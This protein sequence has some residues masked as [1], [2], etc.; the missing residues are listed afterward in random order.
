MTTEPKKLRTFNP[1]LAIERFDDERELFI[2]TRLDT[3]AR[4]ALR[5]SANSASA[6]RPGYCLFR[7]GRDGS[8]RDPKMV[9]P[10]GGVLQFDSAKPSATAGET[11]PGAD[12]SDVPVFEAAW[13]WLLAKN[14]ADTP[15]LAAKPTRLVRLAKSGADGEALLRAD[16]V[17]ADYAIRTSVSQLS[18]DADGATAIIGR[19]E[20]GFAAAGVSWIF[21]GTV[22]NR[23]RLLLVQTADQKSDGFEGQIRPIDE[24]DEVLASLRQMDPQTPVRI[25]PVAQIF[26]GAVAKD[27]ARRIADPV[28]FLTGVNVPGTQYAESGFVRCNLVVGRHKFDSKGDDIPD[29]TAQR[30]LTVCG[31]AEFPEP[32]R[33]GTV[34]LAAP[35]P[36]A[37]R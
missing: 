22:E 8:R 3:R 11:A 16:V 20:N 29:E 14:P 15:V 30:F 26:V 18:Q 1:A 4:V 24:F 23:N 34:P 17:D 5:L 9:V 27:S 2:G 37:A 31:F 7:R 12:G 13:A 32:Y 28:K 36:E 35:D 10:L 25:A 6:R 19:F 21:A 33:P